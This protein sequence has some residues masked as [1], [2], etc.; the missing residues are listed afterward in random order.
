MISYWQ[1]NSCL[2]QWNSNL[3]FGG[4]SRKETLEPLYAIIEVDMEQH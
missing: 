3:G 2:Y 1:G 4:K